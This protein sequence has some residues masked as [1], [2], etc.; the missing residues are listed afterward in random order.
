MLHL[1]LRTINFILSEF[2]KKL[3]IYDVETYIIDDFRKVLLLEDSLALYV[4]I[5]KSTSPICLNPLNNSLVSFALT[6][7]NFKNFSAL[8]SFFPF[9]YQVKVISEFFIRA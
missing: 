3:K 8:P 6:S 1:P 2:E 9:L 4:G 7:T 5:E